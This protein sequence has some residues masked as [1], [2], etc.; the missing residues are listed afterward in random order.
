MRVLGLSS[1]ALLSPKAD[2]E[3]L[4]AL[5]NFNQFSRP[6]PVAFAPPPP[7]RMRILS[8]A[9]SGPSD[10]TGQGVSRLV[11][12]TN[13]LYQPIPLARTDIAAI[14]ADESAVLQK[15]QDTLVNPGTSH[16]VK[17][18]VSLPSTTD[19][20]EDA[21]KAQ[22]LAKLFNDQLIGLRATL[23]EI[24]KIAPSVSGKLGPIETNLGKLGKDT[25]E[26]TQDISTIIQDSQ[27]I[28]AGAAG[29]VSDI[30]Q[31]ATA[32]SQVISGSKKPGDLL[33]Q[34]PLQIEKI[35]KEIVQVLGGKLALVQKV[36]DLF[37]KG[38]DILTDART[39]AAL[40]TVFFDHMLN[41]AQPAIDQAVANLQP[42][43]EHV[44][45]AIPA[46]TAAATDVMAQHGPIVETIIQKAAG[47]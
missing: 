36:K 19:L 1:L 15:A 22:E 5:R 3:G 24:E 35:E 18:L 2:V 11:S 32:I 41:R 31:E 13:D 46:A 25:V 27:S 42:A 34:L 4:G 9:T 7:S 43:L 37:A 38:S 17:T 40:L 33:D 16:S 23:A 20:L 12:N 26:G 21:K 28:A 14:K 47:Q 30:A 10:S 6:H 45:N 8:K 29:L 44:A 39:L